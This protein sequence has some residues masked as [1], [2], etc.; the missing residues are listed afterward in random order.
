MKQRNNPFKESEKGGWDLSFLKI[1]NI[2]HC[3]KQKHIVK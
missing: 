3:F 2:L 1:I